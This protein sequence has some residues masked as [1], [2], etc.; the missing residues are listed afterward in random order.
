MKNEQGFQDHWVDIGPERLARHET[1]SRSRAEGTY[2][3]T[4]PQFIGTA[5][6]PATSA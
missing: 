5:T 4:S 2:F 1:M 6:A 3:A